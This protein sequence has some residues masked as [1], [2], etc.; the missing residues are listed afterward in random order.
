MSGRL[1]L[2]FLVVPAV[3]VALLGTVGARLGFGPTFA[4]VVLSAVVGS[5]LARRE[6]LAAWGR[7]QARLAA[8]GVPGPELVDGLVVLVSATLLVA[9]GFLTDLV[10]MVG[11]FPPTRALVRRA[12]V[13][14]FERG[15]SRGTIR[16]S[17][18]GGAFSPFGAPTG[19][20]PGAEA[21]VEDAEV[22][23]DGRPRTPIR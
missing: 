20:F 12:L 3:E 9:P 7:V 17:G 21:T 13:R 10:G 1:L 15:A 22:I 16:V 14:R 2:L 23:D 19:G 8:G 6:G 4:L 11:L 18:P 5:W